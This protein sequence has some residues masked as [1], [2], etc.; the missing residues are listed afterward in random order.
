[1]PGSGSQTITISGVRLD[2]REATAP[3]TATFTGDANAF[4]SGVATVI[5]AI[6]DALEVESAPAQILT[7]GAAGSATV[8]IKEAFASAFTAEAD[9]LLTLV[10]VPDEA[11]LSVMHVQP[12]NPDDATD[13]ADV[14]GNVTLNTDTM[15]V[16]GGDTTALALPTITGDGDKINITVG[17]TGPNAASTESV[18]LMFDL[19]ASG[20]TGATGGPRTAS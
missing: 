3:V 16:T 13:D 11:S 6:E 15:I 2:L 18:T 20:D 5:S 14:A 8:T 9:I 4:V 12:A 10:G 17:F 1:M 7:R 19:D